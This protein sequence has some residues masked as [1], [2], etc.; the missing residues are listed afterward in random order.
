LYK[1]EKGIAYQVTLLSWVLCGGSTHE[2]Y[3]K[4]DRNS[5]Y[6]ECG[7]PVYDLRDFNAINCVIE[8]MLRSMAWLCNE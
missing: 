8:F 6:I 2:V 1:I 7:K 4:M 3:R 5:K